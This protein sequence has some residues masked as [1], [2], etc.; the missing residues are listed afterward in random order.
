MLSL[1]GPALEVRTRADK[2]AITDQA[3]AVLLTILDQK[4]TV[5]LSELVAA[6]MEGQSSVVICALAMCT[7]I[8]SPLGGEL[9]KSCLLSWS[10]QSSG[11]GR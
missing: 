10:L 2:M 7:Y 8:F 4:V 9:E 6:E 1:V 3:L 5:L 11:E